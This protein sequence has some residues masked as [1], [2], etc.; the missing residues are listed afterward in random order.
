MRIALS[1]LIVLSRLF[2]YFQG[3]L[4]LIVDTIDYVGEL[5]SFQKRKSDAIEIMRGH[6]YKPKR[7]EKNIDYSGKRIYISS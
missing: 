4:S 2:E 6:S 1:I 7:T 5:N 3:R